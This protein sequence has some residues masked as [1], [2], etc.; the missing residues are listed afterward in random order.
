MDEHEQMIAEMQ[1]KA[2]EAQ[3]Q[4]MEQSLAM[5]KQ[6]MAQMG[7][8]MPEGAYD[9]YMQ[10]IMKQQTQMQ[11]MTAEEMLEAAKAELA[12]SGYFEED[13]EDE[14]DEE[15]MKAFIAANPVP[16]DC[17]RYLP[18]GALLIGTWSEPYETL[19]VISD[20]EDIEGAL[21]NGWGIESRE[22]GLEM[23]NSLMAGRHAQKFKKTHEALKAGNFDEVDEDDAEDYA[24]SVKGITDALEIPQS[25]VDN[26]ETLL[27]WD[28]ERVGYL[29]RLF[30]K[31]GYLSEDEAWDWIKK[32]AAETKKTFNS[33]EEYIVSVL[34]GRGLAMGVAQ[35]PYLVA[36]DLLHDSKPFLDSRPISN[37]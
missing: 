33:W 21:E 32:A 30:V 35:E 24:L 1:K 17:D 2:L 18:I 8:E 22:D 5:Q 36:Y 14:Y 34:I 23:L 15:E 16:A 9:E 7:V 31:I 4:M 10:Q 19:A 27:A 20:V 25:L 11:T 28:L 37:L 26:C 13:D 3:K 12:E 29:A 6:M